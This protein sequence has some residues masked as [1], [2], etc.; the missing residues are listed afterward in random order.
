MLPGEWGNGRERAM[1]GG[2]LKPQT[3]LKSLAHAAVRFCAPF[4]QG[5]N[6]DPKTETET[7]WRN[8]TANGSIIRTL[9]TTWQ[10]RRW[11]FTAMEERMDG[12]WP[13][14][15]QRV[16]THKQGLCATRNLS[17]VG[18]TP[19]GGI[20]PHPWLTKHMTGFQRKMAQ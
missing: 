6:A 19:M 10:R 7:E 16:T 18:S 11:Q 3:P 2:Q 9:Q 13:R 14:Q 12:R 1:K 20:G 8:A 4:L 17:V 5:L 15:P